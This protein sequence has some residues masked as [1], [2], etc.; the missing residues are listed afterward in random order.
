MCEAL[1]PENDLGAPTWRDADMVDRA[2]E[3]WDELPPEARFLMEALYGG[4]ELAGAAFAPALGRLSA[5]PVERRYRMLDRM[6]RSRVWPLRFIAEAVKTSST[7]VYMSHPA[8]LAHIGV[9]RDCLVEGEQRLPLT[10]EPGAFSDLIAPQ[11]A[12]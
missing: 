5:L 12:S 2:G 1:Y 7:M 10:R 4:L 3:L 6:R 9:E 11:E 8:V